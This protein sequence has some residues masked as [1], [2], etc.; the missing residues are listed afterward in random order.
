MVKKFSL[1]VSCLA[2]VNLVIWNF[3]YKLGKSTG[4]ILGTPFYFLRLHCEM[5]DLVFNNL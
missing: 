4:S 3:G 1:Y 5:K 2:L